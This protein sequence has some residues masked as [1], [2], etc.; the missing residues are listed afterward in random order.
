[1][2]KVGVTPGLTRRSSS[3]LIWVLTLRPRPSQL[4]AYGSMLSLEV[5]IVHR[6][7]WFWQPRDYWV[8]WPT[9]PEL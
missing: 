2:W 3:L 1:M 9:Q 4:T 6:E 5:L 7:P 8:G